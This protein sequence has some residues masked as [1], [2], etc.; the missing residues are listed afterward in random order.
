MVHFYTTASIKT[1]R[2]KNEAAGSIKFGN[3]RIFRGNKFL[4]IGYF[5]KFRYINYS[6]KVSQEHFL[7]KFFSL[8]LL[9]LLTLTLIGVTN[10]VLVS[11]L[12]Q[13]DI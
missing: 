3:F 5:E 6:S 12:V 4:Q 1:A 11:L 2:K 9:V 8:N 7:R 10:S 13:I